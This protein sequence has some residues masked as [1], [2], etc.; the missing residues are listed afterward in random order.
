MTATAVGELEADTGRAS[1][2]VKPLSR[3]DF[4]K[5]GGYTTD[6]RVSKLNFLYRMAGTTLDA[7][8]YSNL[9]VEAARAAQEQAVAAKN[10][11]AAADEAGS[12]RV[13]GS[14]R[15]HGGSGG[16]IGPAPQSQNKRYVPGR[17]GNHCSVGAGGAGQMSKKATAPKKRPRWS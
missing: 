11:S 1:G 14:G 15:G 16:D 7:A 17:G 8:F 6:E 2:G 9:L 13:D 3:L 12:R 4:N 10:T 5:P